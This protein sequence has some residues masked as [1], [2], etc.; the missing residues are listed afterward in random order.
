MFVFIKKKEAVQLV[1]SVG[2]LERLCEKLPKGYRGE[3]ALLET[4]AKLYVTFR[5]AVRR[6][7]I[8]GYA[9][10]GRDVKKIL[11]CLAKF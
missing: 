11:D 8:S 10:D 7:A 9:Y 2:N 6:Y 1:G 4:G 5:G 3:I